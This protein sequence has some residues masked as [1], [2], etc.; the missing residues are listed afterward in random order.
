M[1]MFIYGFPGVGIVVRIVYRVDDNVP[2]NITPPPAQMRQRSK[3]LDKKMKKNKRLAR[4][5]Y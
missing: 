2:E 5:A 1:A 3:M 4:I